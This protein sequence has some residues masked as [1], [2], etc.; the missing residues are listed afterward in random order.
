ME[1]FLQ[2]IF[3]SIVFPESAPI[4]IHANELDLYIG[5]YIKIRSNSGGSTAAR[6]EE[7]E[8]RECCITFTDMEDNRLYKSNFDRHS[9]IVVYPTL[10]RC[11]N[12]LIKI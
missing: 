4:T 8:T 6:I 11:E 1:H 10:E 12:M 3:D 9:D 7:I 2:A 5:Y